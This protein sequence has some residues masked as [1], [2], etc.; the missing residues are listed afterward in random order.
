MANAKKE[1]RTVNLGL[2]VMI[3]IALFGIV[4]LAKGVSMGIIDGGSA[5][6]FG[7]LFLTFFGLLFGVPIVWLVTSEKRKSLRIAVLILESERTKIQVLAGSTG[8]S[9]NAAKSKIVW[10]IE[11]GY[12]PGYVIVGDEVLLSRHVNPDLQEHVCECPNCNA[13]FTYVGRI[14][15]CP[16]CG[17]YYP[18]RNRQ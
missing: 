6:F 10:C 2:Y 9:D 8:I 1:L 13:S 14:G 3:V 7:G 16:Y 4:L 17:D 18:P 11:R 12:L 15:Q 5:Y